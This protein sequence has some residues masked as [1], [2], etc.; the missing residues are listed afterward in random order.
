[1]RAEDHLLYI[2]M[3]LETHM[4]YVM[5]ERIQQLEK[6]LTEGITENQAC[7][8]PRSRKE[9]NMSSKQ[10]ETS[11]AAILQQVQRERLI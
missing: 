4:T 3:K 5:Q 2:C 6:G 10:V 9:A 11:F 7:L 8:H 1:M